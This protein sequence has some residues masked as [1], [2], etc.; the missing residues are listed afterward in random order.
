MEFHELFSIAVLT[1]GPAAF[2]LR[3]LRRRDPHAARK[4]NGRMVLYFF[5]AGMVSAPLCML[6]YFSNPYDPWIDSSV[7][8]Y[9]LV[10]APSEELAKFLVFWVLARVLGSVKDP[11]DA[12]IQGA[13]VGVGKPSGI[14]GSVKA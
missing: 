3:W 5:A 9:F 13:A 14:P 10:N 1:A 2:W 8:Y 12:L 6:F 4:R 7:P 11:V